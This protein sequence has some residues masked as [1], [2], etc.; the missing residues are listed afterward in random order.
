MFLEVYPQVLGVSTHKRCTKCGQYKPADN[1]HF[2]VSRGKLRADCK[3]CRKQYNEQYYASNSARLNEYARQYRASNPGVIKRL[4]RQYYDDNAERLR[5]YAREYRQ[6]HPE[7]AAEYREE[8][9][10]K[11]K[12]Q[13]RKWRTVN[14]DRIAEYGYRYR[15]ENDQWFKNYRRS[16][17]G[18]AVSRTGTSNRR[19][20]KASAAGSFTTAD[21][22]AIRA[23]QTD[24]Q[25]RLICWHCGK[26]IKGTPHLDHW[27]P[28]DKDG[29]NYAGN[30][31]FMH[32]KCNLEKGAKHP[33]DTGRLI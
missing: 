30:L 16:D 14:A 9:A 24:K 18:R 3:E 25:G 1:D 13:K 10:D 28:L 2:A 20:R 12:D 19:A 31:H 27:I 21:L 33:H 8:H 7:V 29:T 26:P 22:A 15:A 32:A 11:I 17:R 23:A 4:N 5:K 6:T